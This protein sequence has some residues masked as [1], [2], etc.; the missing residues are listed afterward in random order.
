[1]AQ[2]SARV[3]LTSAAAFVAVASLTADQKKLTEDQ[4]M[5]ILRGLDSE[6]ATVK[7]PLPRSRAP[8]DVEIDGTYDKQHWDQAGK[9]FGSAARV[10]DLVQITKVSI[11]PT[12]IVFEING[13]L[14]A[15]GAWKDHISV[16]VGIPM[17]INGGNNAVSTGGTTIALLFHQPIGEITSSDVKKMLAP[18][19]D[20]N[21]QSVTVPYTAT[22]TPEVKTA[23]ENKKAI[24]GMD[25]DQVIMALGRPAHK[26]RE[27]K[28]GT[29]YEDWIYG[30]PPGRVVFVTF[31]G[32]KVVKVKETYAGLGGSIAGNPKQ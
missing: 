13:G 3:I 26:D 5:E 18:V 17:P 22:L 9:Q 24:E 15:K 19:L 4:R 21:Q 16:G 2:I 27:T 31:V 32:N 29:E 23:I 20:F 6:Y 12:M 10:G 7:V 8:L 28:D 14:R 30:T 25:R 11:E 1:M